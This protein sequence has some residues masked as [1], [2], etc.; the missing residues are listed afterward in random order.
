MDHSNSIRTSWEANAANWIGT[1]ANNEIESRVLVTNEAIVQA[2]LAVSPAS[3]LDIG[4]GEGWL[5]RL[6]RSKGID[7]YGVDAVESLISYAIEKDGPHYAVA[8]FRQLSDGTFSLPQ[9]AAAAVIN[10]ALLDEADTAALIRNMHLLVQPG[11]MVIIQTLHPLVIAMQENYISGWKE[12]SWNSMKRSFEQP[13]Q[14]YFRTTEDWVKLFTEAG[15]AICSIREPLHPSTQK[16][17]SVIFTL[18]L[19]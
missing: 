8:G 11:G 15:L 18:Q 5:T 12:G 16:P 13:Y 1:I 2:V 3:V 14:W 9:K 6:L 17:A 7:T 10:F 4:C 19:K